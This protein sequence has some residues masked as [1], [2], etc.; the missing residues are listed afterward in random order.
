MD[1][2]L[3]SAQCGHIN[4]KHH[5]IVAPLERRL[6]I[7]TSG[8]YDRRC[9]APLFTGCAVG[10]HGLFGGAEVEERAVIVHHVM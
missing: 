3:A 6:P 1:R 4:R 9:G 7:R 5:G 10:P 8:T 2:M